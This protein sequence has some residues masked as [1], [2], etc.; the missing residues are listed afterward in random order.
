[1]LIVKPIIEL[2]VMNN[3]KLI[4]I[5]LAP[6]D[7]VDRMLGWAILTANNKLKIFNSNANHLSNLHISL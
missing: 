6:Y 5:L 2:K 7:L 3:K 4:V 1:M